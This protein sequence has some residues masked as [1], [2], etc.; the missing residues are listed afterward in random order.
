MS[1]THYLG[2]TPQDLLN[3]G[4]GQ[5]RYFYGLRRTEEGD[6]YITKT[7]Q[8]AGQDVVQV[9]APGDVEDDWEFFEIGVDFLD[10]RDKDT[11]ERPYTN[12]IF[13]QYRWD[14]RSIFYYINDEGELVVRINQAYSYPTD[15]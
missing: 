4:V 14:S 8:F 6:L 3:Y 1:A 15:V 12:L 10:G 11:H 9:N 2:V 7:D 13:D 5:N